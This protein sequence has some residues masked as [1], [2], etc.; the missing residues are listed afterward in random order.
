MRQVLGACEEAGGRWVTTDDLRQRF[1]RQEHPRLAW[2]YHLR[3]AVNHSD[4]EAI[5]RAIRRLAALGRIEV[6]SYPR[7]RR[8]RLISN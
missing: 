4:E 2:G 7:H 1:C 5:N 3:Y 6:R 8:V